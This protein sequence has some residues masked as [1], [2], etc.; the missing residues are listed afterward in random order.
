MKTLRDKLCQHFDKEMREDNLPYIERKLA[1]YRDLYQKLSGN[2]AINEYDIRNLVNF[3][4][5]L[6]KQKK[7]TMDEFTD[8]FEA[9]VKSLHL[10]GMYQLADNVLSYDPKKLFSMAQYNDNKASIMRIEHEFN[11]KLDK[12][13]K[14]R[15]PQLKAIIEQHNLVGVTV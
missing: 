14:R 1:Y 2:E 3:E 9:I 10:E 13:Q 6:K 7:I 15:I 5:E 8:Q 12:T 11:T 4:V